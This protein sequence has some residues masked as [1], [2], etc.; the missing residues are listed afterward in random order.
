MVEPRYE[1]KCVKPGS[2]SGPW[3]WK[4]V[5]L[6][7]KAVAEVTHSL[8]SNSEIIQQKLFLEALWK[9]LGGHSAGEQGHL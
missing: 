3:R 1:T 5:I 9:E 6:F 4:F 8:C 2:F 7:F